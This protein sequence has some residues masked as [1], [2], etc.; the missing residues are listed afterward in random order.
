MFNTSIGL[1]D[2]N[3]L[4]QGNMIEHLGIEFTEITAEY[5]KAK[6]PVDHRTKQPFGLLHGGASVVLAETLGSIASALAVS[7]M[8]LFKGVGVEINANHLKSARGGYVTGICVPLRIG[9]TLHVYDIKIYDETEQLICASRLTVA[10][11][12]VD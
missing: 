12:K 1:D 9:K 10:I 5:I 2:I 6:M 3:A 8:N 4:S 11:L 7:D